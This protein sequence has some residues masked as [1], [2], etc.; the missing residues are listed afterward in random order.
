MHRKVFLLN[1]NTLA[2]TTGYDKCKELQ[3][4]NAPTIA[5]QLL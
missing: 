2:P 4:Y 3:F 5:V 1:V